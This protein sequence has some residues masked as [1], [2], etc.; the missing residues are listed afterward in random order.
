MSDRD[1]NLD[2]E[3]SFPPRD[4]ELVSRKLTWMVGK[5]REDNSILNKEK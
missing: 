2:A 3:I 1:N 5:K 4:E